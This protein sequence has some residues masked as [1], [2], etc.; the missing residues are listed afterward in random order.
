M[1]GLSTTAKNFIDN[2]A[3]L[4]IMYEMKL[5]SVEEACEKIN[6]FRAFFRLKPFTTDEFIQQFADV[7]FTEGDY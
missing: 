6:E 1:V 7:R 2:I 4:M 3:G 5:I